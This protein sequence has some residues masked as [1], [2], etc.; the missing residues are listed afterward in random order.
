MNSFN[1]EDDTIQI[2]RKYKGFNVNI[3]TFLQS[4]FP[5]IHKDTLMPL[6]KTLADKD[7]DESFYPPGIIDNVY[8]CIYPI[9]VNYSEISNIS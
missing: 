5:R 1:T 9:I 6:A 2:L 3:F 8:L 7:N 4:R